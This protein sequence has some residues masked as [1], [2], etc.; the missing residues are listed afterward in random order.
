MDPPTK[1]GQPPVPESPSCGGG[2]PNAAAQP[3]QQSVEMQPVMGAPVM[4]APVAQPSYA[5]G[6]PPP[7]YNAYGQPY[8]PGAQ[9]PAYG[10][11]PPGYG[12]GAPAGG[13]GLAQPMIAPNHGMHMMPP[14]QLPDFSSRLFSSCNDPQSQPNKTCLN[15]FFCP[16]CTA[17]R[18]LTAA[19]G[20]VP[21]PFHWTC[22][23]AMVVEAVSISLPIV[24]GR[25]SVFSFLT[26]AIC[27]QNAWTRGYV[28]RRLGIR[29]SIFN[30]YLLSWFCTPCAIAQQQTEMK[31]NHVNPGAFCEPPVT[32][33]PA[34]PMLMM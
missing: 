34:G 19:E 13:G 6:Q 30:D 15:A 11:P 16:Y 2:Y 4:G 25:Y 27:I 12:P 20:K 17:A 31:I 22:A 21:T 29:S 1:P 23:L 26:T 33:P 32:E 14:G 28:R 5:Y 3:Q 10:A 9:Q 18:Q 8:G 7:A 24:L